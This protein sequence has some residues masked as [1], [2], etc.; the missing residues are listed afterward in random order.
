M[1]APAAT[2]HPLPPRRRW[3]LLRRGFGYGA[4]LL[5]IGLAL[6][7]ALGSLLLPLAERHPAQ[8]AA[9][10]SARAGQPVAFDRVH[11]AWTR[12]GPLLR[13]DGLRIGAGPAPLR[14]GDAE[15]LVAQYTGWLPW[16]AFTELRLHGLDLTLQRL[17]DGHWQV[18]GLPRQPGGGDPLE[19][20]RRLGE[21]QVAQ[22]R[23]RVL[24]PELGLD[25]AFPTVDLRL[26][27]H[28]AR[29]QAGVRARSR[30]DAAPVY[31]AL[32][33]ARDRGDGRLYLQAPRLD[34]RD[35]RALAPLAG[36]R[37]AAGRG[38]AEAWL[39]L[40]GG[41]VVGVRS[42][43][44]L[45]GV[46]LAGAPLA[47]G[48]P[49][50]TQ[51]LG[52]LDFDLDWQGTLRQ[53]QARAL[54]LRVGGGRRAQTL[55]GLA[56]AGGGRYA[57]RAARIDA[58]PLLAWAALSDRLPPGLRRW[59]LQARP[60][61]VA[62]DLWL[63]AAA[64]DRLQAGARLRALGF[65]PVG[66]A[67]GLQGVAG[68]L[69]ADGH[70]LRLRFDPQAQAVFDW[71][72]GFGVAHAFRADGEAVAWRDDAGW[73]VQTPGL[74]LQV[75]AVA[76]AV[77]GGIGF[78]AEGGR[79]RLDLAA[80]VGP[81]P[82]TAARGFWVRY[83]MPA[84]TVRWLDTA[85]QGGWVRDAHAV[86][87][88]DL[89]D[90]PFRAEAGR[91]GA[92]RFRIDARIAEGRVKFQPDWP[93]AEQVD[94]A[95]AF[96]ADGFGLSG[97][98]RLAGVPVT[99]LRA[100]I[101]RFGQAELTVDAETAGEAGAVLALLRA[102]P[103]RRE[104]GS[105]LDGLQA[106]GPVQGDFHLRLP[107]YH[108]APPMQVEGQ[109]Q[110][111]DVALREDGWGLAFDGVRG[112]LRYDRAGILAEGL[113]VR[114]DGQ[115]G[116]LSLRSGPHAQAPGLAFEAELQASVGIDQVLAHAGGEL[117]WLKPWM[118]GRSPWSA[119]LAVP[120]G[121]AAG[122]GRL[123]L[124]SSLVGTAIGLPPPL[125]KPAAAAWPVQVDLSLPLAQ[126]EVAVDLG[127]VLSLRSRGSG[128]Q[129]G[130]QLRLGGGAAAAP[131]G[132]GLWIDGRVPQLDPLDWSAVLAGGGSRG[133][134]PLRRVEL[135]VGQ[136][137]LL[138]A[139]F[140][141][142]ALTLAP[143]AG[144]ERLQ[145]EG[146]AL[147]GVL[148]LPNARGAPI[149]GRFSRLDWRP[150]AL[151][152][153]GAAATATPTAAAAPDPARIPPLQ[154]DVAD[155]R[156]GGLAFGGAR[157]RTQPSADGLRLEELSTH[158]AG[159]RLQASGHWSGHAGA[160]QTQ[161]SARL[162][163]DDVGRLLGALGLGGQLAGGHGRLQLD[164]GWHGG[165]QAL[166]A[167]GLQAQLAVDV[168]DGRL[169][170][171]EPGAGRVLGLLGIAQLPR[172]LTLDFRDFFDKGF[173]FDRLQGSARVGGGQVQTDDLDIRGPAA[174]IRVRGS[175]DL[176]GQRLDQ[177]VDVYPH[178]G[179]VLTAVGALAGGPVGAAV[180]AVA[181]AVLD[182][183]MQDLG[184][185]S[186]R[187]RGAW[188]A[189]QVE[190][191]ARPAPLPR[192]RERPAAD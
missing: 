185:R 169:L 99:S 138:G 55:D 155:L 164:A 57:V 98:A 162:D 23:L 107:F 21:L 15:L 5:A 190:A 14:I 187:I 135:Q 8:I 48:A 37:A 125:R 60:S 31:A 78:P 129:A 147:A 106:R 6:G 168:R 64:P 79:P 108:P 170:Q 156:V 51:A 177:T 151:A 68:D 92:G 116:L 43:G 90:W 35:W 153:P 103:L 39:T 188:Q 71:P 101:A 33:V 56:V 34:L 181:N 132:S 179:G 73:Q 120:Q 141:D 192:A 84:E 134:P 102:S 89:R 66:H 44:R 114:H 93:A 94:G 76:V 118:D 142:T 11:T 62:E 172:R 49:L 167:A 12:R 96:E 144:G 32:D 19:A 143:V 10:L 163:S 111:Q 72:S 7:N 145:L 58:G 77:R 131:S 3:R 149:V 17:A 175:A 171:V 20:L 176:V 126:G 46:A 81:A 63:D 52:A 65:A 159:Q 146:P 157:L 186:Y 30:A 140:A 2:A 189:P 128:P 80:D 117:D 83:L 1:T 54:R 122:Q 88:G 173:A 74:A 133:G 25:L 137:H 110:L 75:D 121:A 150:P 9:W 13:L 178:S 86:V 41:R 183:P 28:G 130:V 69:R 87:A 105:V 59:L 123:A 112:R 85:L 36:L 113:Q 191:Q 91:A 109:V 97:R 100:G 27:V 95:L 67:P 47:P 182:R 165:P 29:L 119:R 45:E 136:L 161:L 104:V 42:R 4:L 139:D 22:A 26:Q 82:V 148:T 24:A 53:W 174:E 127:D 18:R 160:A 40:R 184:A 16:R 115:P 166:T 124:R 158:G 152:W 154:I 61:G 180:G 70:G 38:E 50:P